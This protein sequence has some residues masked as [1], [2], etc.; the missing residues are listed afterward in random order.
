[1]F[2]FSFR[3]KLT[4]AEFGAM[5]SKGKDCRSG[6]CLIS[7]VFG[8]CTTTCS[9]NENCPK[10]ASC[11]AVGDSKS[12]VQQKT[13]STFCADSRECESGL[14]LGESSGPLNR[15][16]H[17]E[18]AAPCASG[19]PCPSGQYCAAAGTVLG[20]DVYGGGLS[21]PACLD[22]KPVGAACK[23]STE[24]S[25]GDCAA[26]FEVAGEADAGAELANL[27]ALFKQCR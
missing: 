10:N 21:Q 7:G 3:H 4:G 22:Q 24:C 14:C 17:G 26:M 5:C 20:A 9:E 18:C 12:C 13:G 1:M 8:S 19:E 6:E 27:V 25:S 15:A 11:V 16:I 23:E 2:A